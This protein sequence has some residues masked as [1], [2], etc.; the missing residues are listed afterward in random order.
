MKVEVIYKP[1]KY[2]KGL[3]KWWPWCWVIK[4]AKG[5]SITISQTLKPRLIAVTKDQFN[6]WKKQQFTAIFELGF[7]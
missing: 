6:N 7:K 5:E 2:G 4:D 1:D 3:N